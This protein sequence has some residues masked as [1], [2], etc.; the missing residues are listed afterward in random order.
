MFLRWKKRKFVAKDG[1]EDVWLAAQIVVSRRINGK[2]RQK[3]I[4]AL[5]RIRQSHLTQVLSRWYFWGRIIRNLSRVD[6]G[7]ELY[8]KFERQIL[9]TVQKPTYKEADLALEEN[10]RRRDIN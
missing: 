7:N 6:I 1:A 5:G 4:K 8:N 2:P 9:E 3:V 10:H